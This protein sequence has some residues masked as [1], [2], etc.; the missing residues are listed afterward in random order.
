MYRVLVKAY[1]LRFVINVTGKAGKFN[2][3]PLLM[4]LGS[5]LGL[6]SVATIVADIFLLYLTSEKKFYRELKELDYKNKEDNL[7][8]PIKKESFTNLKQERI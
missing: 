4:A 8:P 6:L 1:G 7:T 2:L 3:V 5:G